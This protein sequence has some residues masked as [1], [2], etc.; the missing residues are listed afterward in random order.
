[1][2]V[3]PPG[4]FF[5]SHHPIVHLCALLLL[6]MKNLFMRKPQARYA[7][8][9]GERKEGVGDVEGRGERGG[10]RTELGYY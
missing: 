10:E 8:R 3:F 9:Q 6:I 4:T 1:M 7:A 5:I 2:C